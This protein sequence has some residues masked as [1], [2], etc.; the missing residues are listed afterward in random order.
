MTT[1]GECAVRHGPLL[2]N[3][4]V[5]PLEE[6]NLKPAYA[7]LGGQWLLAETQVFHALVAVAVAVVAAGAAAAAAAAAATAAAVTAAAYPP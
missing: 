7:L 1:S 4:W 2:Y 5:R 3:Y 6:P